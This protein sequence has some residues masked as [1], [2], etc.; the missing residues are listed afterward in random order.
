MDNDYIKGIMNINDV[1]H[2]KGIIDTKRKNKYKR[3]NYYEKE[4][5]ILKS[6]LNDEYILKGIMNKG[7]NKY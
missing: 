5:G 7:N 2:K 1:I 6:N 4:S 3:N